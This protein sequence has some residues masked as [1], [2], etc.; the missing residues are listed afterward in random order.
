MISYETV[1][2]TNYRLLTS[3]MSI[4]D[5]IINPF[6]INGNLIPEM[7]IEVDTTDNY[8]NIYVPSFTQVDDV[9]FN[10]STNGQTNF[11]IKIVKISDDINFVNV[12]CAPFTKFSG[13]I[14]K[15]DVSTIQLST[16]TDSLE[17]T[18]I[19]L[20]KTNTYQVIINVSLSLQRL[21]PIGLPA[22]NNYEAQLNLAPPII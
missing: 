4:Q 15:I 22:D 9:P 5:F 18:P 3:K 2:G 19:G 14:P 21:D 12:I 7:I 20:A 13:I 17:I 10:I 11:I 8:A 1:Q 6:D 16:I